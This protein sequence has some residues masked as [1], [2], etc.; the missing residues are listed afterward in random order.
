MKTS[1]VQHGVRRYFD[2]KTFRC[3]IQPSKTGSSYHVSN[4]P[5]LLRPQ[6][7]GGRLDFVSRRS[8]I[9]IQLDYSNSRGASQKNAF[10]HLQPLALV[11]GHPADWLKSDLIL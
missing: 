4:V 5:E 8:K 2:V 6:P 9:A 3:T 10:E 1:I 11:Q 7:P